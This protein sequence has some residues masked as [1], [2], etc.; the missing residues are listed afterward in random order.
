MDKTQ[1]LVR[2]FAPE[3]GLRQCPHKEQLLKDILQRSNFSIQSELRAL[4]EREQCTTYNCVLGASDN[5]REER[6]IIVQ[7]DC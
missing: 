3:G 7:A 1:A 6:L 4:R 2:T 5:N